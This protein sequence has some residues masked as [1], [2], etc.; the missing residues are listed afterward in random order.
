MYV[1]KD[2]DPNSTYFMAVDVALGRGRDYSAFQIIDLY[3]GEQVAEFYSNTTPIN[4]FA[5]ICFDE[6]TYYNLC[7]V[8]VERNT[9]GN[10]L[11]D[12]LFE[13]LEYENVWFDE[14][15]Q[16]GLQIT[17]KNRDNI[18]VE[19]EE[20]IRMNEVKINSK[21]T[22]MELNTFIISDNGKV[23]ADTG[24]NDDLVMSLA[25]SIYGGRRYREENPEIVKFNPAKEKKPMSI[26][27]S[28][29]LLSSKG[30]IQEDITWLIK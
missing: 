5:R 4:E 22:V 1:W 14:K 12:Y 15:Q 3:S 24:Q 23:K 13:Q 29:Q 11:L 19:M 25:L 18:L 10:N 26:L 2:P 8:L 21:R 7:P 17:A 6:G 9:I 28:H 30:T 16:M 20:A 27:S